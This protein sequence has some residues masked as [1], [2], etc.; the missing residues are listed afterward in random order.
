MPD[1]IEDQIAEDALQPK[2]VEV[3]GIR[4]KNHDLDDLIKADRYLESKNAT[5]RGLG[6]KRTKMI[7]PGAV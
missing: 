1:A 5:S 3:D 7:P 2:E 4:S 6:I